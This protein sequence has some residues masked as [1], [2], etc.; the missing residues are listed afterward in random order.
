MRS[1]CFYHNE[2][3]NK[4]SLKVNIFC[5]FKTYLAKG[6][7]RLNS[8]FKTKKRNAVPLNFLSLEE[9]WLLYFCI[10][11]SR[12]YL[13]LCSNIPYFFIAY[14]FMFGSRPETIYSFIIIFEWHRVWY[15]SQSRFMTRTILR[16]LTK[17]DD[18]TR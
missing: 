8:N 1:Y 10:G 6:W 2:K 4:K 12:K 9:R 14:Q 7:A 16:I 11:L 18:A 5:L 15:E 13:I 17:L 3:Y